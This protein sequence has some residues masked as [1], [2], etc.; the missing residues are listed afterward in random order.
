[1][2]NNTKKALCKLN[3]FLISFII[4]MTEST[5][6]YA[7]KDGKENKTDTPVIEIQYETGT[8]NNARDKRDETEA[9][10]NENDG[11]YEV[12][13]PG[14]EIVLDEN[15]K[16]ITEDQNEEENEEVVWEDIHI[17]SPEEYEEFAKNCRLDTWS[18]NKNVY[19]DNDI[20]IT[21]LKHQS[22]A[23]FGGHFYGQNHEINGYSLNEARSYT[24]LFNY[25]QEGA[26]I[27]GLSVKASIR[28]TGKQVVTGGIVG[29]NH[30]EINNCKFE[31]SIFGENYVGGICGYNE[32]TG[33]IVNCKSFGEISGSYYTGGIAGENVGNISSSTNHA[34]VNTTNIDRALSIQDVDLSSYTDEIIS[35]LTGKEGEKTADTNVVD[36]GAV[37]AGGIAGL[38]IG[39]IQFCD[40]YG[41]V[42]YEHVG[43]N[44][45]GIVGR[46]SGY[47]HGCV[48]EG[49]VRGRK[50]VGGICGQAEPYVVVDLTEDTIQKLSEN[51]DKL[52]DIIDDTLSDAG[53]SSDIISSRLSVVKQFTDKALSET[54]F[55]SDK[56]IDW[57]NGMVGAGNE[58]MSRAQYIMSETSKNGGPI[59][60]TSNAMNDVKAAS[61][62]FK[63]AMEAANIKNYMTEQEKGDFDDASDRLEF[64]TTNQEKN[65]ACYTNADRN[66][67]TKKLSTGDPVKYPYSQDLIPYDKD[68]V[69]VDISSANYVSKDENPTSNWMTNF[70][71]V[72]KWNSITVWKHADGTVHSGNSCPKDGTDAMT[73]VAGGSVLGT[74]VE[75]QVKNDLDDITDKSYDKTYEQYEAKYTVPPYGYTWDPSNNGVG[76]KNKV[77]SE[78]R[79]KTETLIE[80]TSR[81]LPALTENTSK[82]ASEAAENLQRASGNLQNAGNQT[83]SIISDVSGRGGL[84]MPSLGQDYKDSTQALNAALQGMSDN[85]G[86]LNDEM[87]NSTDIMIDDM[88]EVNDQFNVIMK[89]YTD[90]IDGVIDGDY[91]DNIEDGSM[92]V[93]ATCVDATIADCENNG[94]VE[95][96]IDISGIVGSMGI[97]YDFDLESDITK[98]NDAKFNSV[99]Q[100]KC[101]QRKNINRARVIAQKSFAGGA[102]G[103]QEIGTIL[104]CQNY[105][106]IK[107]NSA[108]YVGGIAGDSMSYIQKSYAK[109][110]LEG[111]NYVGGIA[112][113]GTN[114]LNCYAMV[115]IN[116]DNADSY[117]GAIAGDVADEGKVH[118]NYFVGDELSGIDR[119]S[120]SDAAE[121]V[122]YDVFVAMNDTPADFRRLYAVFYIDDEEVSR[123]ETQYGGSITKDQFP[124]LVKTDGS[125]ANWS[126]DDLE[127]MCFDEELE[128]E[129]TR[130]QSSISTSQTRGNGQSAILVDGQ[131]V[132]GDE[133]IC[134]SMP[135]SGIGLNNVIE[136]WGVTYPSKRDE[137]HMI[138]YKQPDDVE[139]DTVLYVNHAGRWDKLETQQFGA[140]KT[141]DSYGGYI[142]FAVVK[143]NKSYIKEIIIGVCIL[144]LVIACMILI[145]NGKKKRRLQKESKNDIKEGDIDSSELKIEE[146][147]APDD[148]EEGETEDD[149]EGE[150]NI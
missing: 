36:A 39:V 77:T 22:I 55:L 89:L 146:L 37:D 20:I 29:E 61:G 23:T 131:F 86:A 120:F 90:A 107:S 109:C 106:K 18:K 53:D 42:G 94:K 52:H 38:S 139:T 58:F 137:K 93:A 121:P 12:I 79:I 88:S 41:E 95:G 116:E 2:R 100:S 4:L 24:G 118:Y 111:K 49:V 15:G 84:S 113:H 28:V 73:E 92:E 6:V 47:I 31:G 114:I 3:T 147:D 125:Y 8:Q 134:E 128:G 51:I 16:I 81:H 11:S 45:G 112:G 122:D 101:V 130:Y 64:L 117:Y 44:I 138:R 115:R 78:I 19:L 27:N 25:T 126:K 72:E 82:E 123:I 148:T 75:N 140:Y 124:V 76:K 33:N 67:L 13:I 5:G 74:D 63:Q 129:Y 60:S 32:L 133:V 85:M 70:E 145:I 105:G 103:L 91:G 34:R 141:F 14:K 43:Y 108:D 71:N 50:D 135:V 1:M 80:T 46:Q 119:I 59:D 136:H 87:S 142:E 110:F 127:G 143:T 83:K 40:N 48:N 35:K 66:R 54:S 26:I 150:Q 57:T 96:D 99:Y 9:V 69:E 132:E 65:I 30:G 104:Q 62:E 144:L 98:S 149:G 68:G 56:T 97:E 102:C 17:S 7:S 10:K 21:G